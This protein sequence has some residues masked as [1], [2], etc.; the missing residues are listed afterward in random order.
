M[1]SAH[2]GPPLL[3]PLVKTQ[4]ISKQC[5]AIIGG[6]RFGPNPCGAS[7]FRAGH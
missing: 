5:C 7:N 1:A 4:Q 2:A 3:H 6:A